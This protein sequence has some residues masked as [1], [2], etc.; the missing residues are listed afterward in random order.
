MP[1]ITRNHDLRSFGPSAF[2]GGRRILRTNLMQIGHETLGGPTNIEEIHRV[3]SNAGKL[4]TV[5]FA[6]LALFRLGHDF[7]D[8]SATQS[9]GTESEGLKKTI[10]QLSPFF[11]GNQ[12]CY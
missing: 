3:G 11:P 9:T 7:S 4:R 1:R 6:C 2:G 8:R 10:V 5:V 12:F